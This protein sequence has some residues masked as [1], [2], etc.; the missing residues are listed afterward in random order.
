MGFLTVKK[1]IRFGQA[2]IVFIIFISLV[3]PCTISSALPVRAQQDVQTEIDHEQDHIIAF[4]HPVA[5]RARILI[6][7]LAVWDTDMV[8]GVWVYQVNLTSWLDTTP[9]KVEIQVHLGNDYA[10]YC[11]AEIKSGKN[12]LDD[13][14][15]LKQISFSASDTEG[16]GWNRYNTIIELELSR[17]KGSVRP[18]WATP[19]EYDLEH[20]IR[21]KS[22]DL[23]Q[24]VQTCLQTC[25]FSDLMPLIT[26]ALTNQALMEGVSP[27]L[28]IQTM[29]VFL[30]RHCIRNIKIAATSREYYSSTYQDIMA[31]IDYEDMSFRFTKTEDGERGNLFKPAA[32]LEFSTEDNRQFKTRIFL[33]YTNEKRNRRFISRFFFDRTE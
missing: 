21:S 17:P 8:F 3:S 31:P 22:T 16:T 6:D 29:L 4:I 11:K 1:K 32:T 23:I 10:A 14:E 5:S 13:K 26:P 9:S 20:V 27:E 24:E 25:S 19:H 12:L 33:S 7:D 2:R 30:K 28:Y 18:L 15:V